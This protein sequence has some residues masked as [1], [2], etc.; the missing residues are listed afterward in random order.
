MT[1][2]KQVCKVCNTPWKSN[3][4]EPKCPKCPEIKKKQVQVELEAARKK[5]NDGKRKSY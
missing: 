4:K 1:K 2:T 5:I 3:A